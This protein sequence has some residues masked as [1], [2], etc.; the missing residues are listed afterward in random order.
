MKCKIQNSKLRRP[1]SDVSNA[2][3]RADICVEPL[4]REISVYFYS[5]LQHL[6]ACAGNCRPD[7]PPSPRREGVERIGIVKVK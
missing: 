6:P 1:P 5:P 4:A 7:P 3:R 2:T